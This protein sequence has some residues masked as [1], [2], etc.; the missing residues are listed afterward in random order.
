ERTG[1]NVGFVGEVCAVARFE[2]DVRAGAG[3]DHHLVIVLIH[4]DRRVA[5]VDKVFRPVVEDIAFAEGAVNHSGEGRDVETHQPNGVD[6]AGGFG[7]RPD[8]AILPGDVQPVIPVS[9]FQGDV[10]KVA[11]PDQICKLEGE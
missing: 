6:A 5:V 2:I 4:L 10:A 8:H 9:R 7:V 1:A 3:V 11:D